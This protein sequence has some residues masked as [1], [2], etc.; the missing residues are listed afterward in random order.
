M[1]RLLDHQVK[2]ETTGEYCP[3]CRAHVDHDR[4]RLVPIPEQ[5]MPARGEYAPEHRP[6]ESAD[7]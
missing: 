6:D 5:G 4:H 2:L 1:S 7:E 3:E